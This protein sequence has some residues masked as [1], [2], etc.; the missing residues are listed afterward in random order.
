[1]GREKMEGWMDRIEDGK[2]VFGGGESCKYVSVDSTVDS[3]FFL[4]GVYTV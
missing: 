3:Q 1:M 2:G 4:N